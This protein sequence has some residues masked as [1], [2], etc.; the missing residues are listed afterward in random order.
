MIPLPDPSPGLIA[1][2][3]EGGKIGSM[4]NQADLELELRHLYQQWQR[5]GYDAR[6]FYQ[7][8]MKHCKRYKGGVAAVRDVLWKRGTGGFDRLQHLGRPDLTV[9]KYV[10]L[11]PKWNHLFRDKDRVMA[12]RKL[13]ENS[14]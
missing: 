13:A 3:A 11:N 1:R 6:R 12:Q 4:T 8:F 10:V 9:E 7:M 14:K 5:L 2:I